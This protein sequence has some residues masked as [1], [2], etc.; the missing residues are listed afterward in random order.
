[1]KDHAEK[2]NK[3]PPMLCA[4]NQGIENIRK[5]K[6]VNMLPEEGNLKKQNE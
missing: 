3:E 1:M 4:M 5:H 2:R 6:H